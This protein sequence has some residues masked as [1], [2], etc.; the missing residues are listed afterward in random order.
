MRPLVEFFHPVRLRNG[1][2]QLEAAIHL[3][4]GVVRVQAS[5]PE[6]VAARALAKAQ[7]MAAHKLGE[8]AA[9]KL[10]ASPAAP[11]LLLPMRSTVSG[12][13]DEVS[14]FF[15]DIGKA[16]GSVVKSPIFKSV[17]SGVL[18]CVP[19][20][21]SALGD[22]APGLLDAAGNA[23]GA[24]KKG[25]KKGKKAK[26]AIQQNL[27]AARAGNPKAQQ[28]N[29]VLLAQAK[30]GQTPKG[31]KLLKGTL[32]AG[33]LVKL[34]AEGD[35]SAR[36]RIRAIAT[37]AERGRRSSIEALAMIAATQRAILPAVPQLYEGDEDE[38]EG[39]TEFEIE[40]EAV[41]GLVRVAHPRLNMLPPRA[42]RARG[43]RAAM[44]G[45][46]ALRTLGARSRRRAPVQPMG[47]SE[48][49][50]D[51]YEEWEE[52]EA[53]AVVR[54]GSVSPQA[55]RDARARQAALARRLGELARQRPG[56]R[57]RAA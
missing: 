57:R 39:E 13:D 44:P 2:W 9:Q 19:V 48:P 27:A 43:G 24:A 45:T 56:Y 12:E 23:L 22:A 18:K 40:D 4:G 49:W 1:D 51:P 14:G 33:R 11:C 20:V 34:A 30:I 8:K 17:A 35:S 7:A 21:G 54:R 46:L 3:A 10:L 50:E 42:A 6:L 28:V 47:S 55:L 52:D 16:I 15:G 31:Q 25:G 5:A 53:G 38:W 41:E 29:N 36:D 37:A 32:A 26:R